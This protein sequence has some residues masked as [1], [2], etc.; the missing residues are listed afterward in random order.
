THG[1]LSTPWGLK[2][3]TVNRPRFSRRENDGERAQKLGNR[4]VRHR[5]VQDGGVRDSGES[6]DVKRDE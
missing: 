1:I 4:G 6:W 5:G 3:E 2:P